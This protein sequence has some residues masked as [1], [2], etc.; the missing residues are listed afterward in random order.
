[1]SRKFA[2]F[3]IIQTYRYYGSCISNII[4]SKYL[5]YIIQ[6]PLSK[7]DLVSELQASSEAQ[8]ERGESKT[9]P[10]TLTLGGL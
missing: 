8:M 7:E 4:S 3:F 2:F 5:E 9:H 1:M 10:R 6:N